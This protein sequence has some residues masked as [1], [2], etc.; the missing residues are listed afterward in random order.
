MPQLTFLLKQNLKRDRPSSVSCLRYVGLKYGHLVV[1]RNSKQTLKT[2]IFTFIII[3]KII[4]S[5]FSYGKKKFI[6][7]NKS[8]N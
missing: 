8:L 7:V 2:C 5:K 6:Y 4:M 1:A 3:T